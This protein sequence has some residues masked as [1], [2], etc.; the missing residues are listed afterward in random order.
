MLHA[1]M[2]VAVAAA[3]TIAL[4]FAPF[5]IFSGNRETPPLVLYLGK[6]LPAAIM[7]MLVVYCL[8]GTSFA[9]LSGWLPALLASLAVVGLHVWKRSSLLSI[10]GGTVLY[11]LLIRLL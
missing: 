10:L 1:G 9:A 5:L 7:G 6:V 3:V 2:I 4:R 8:R 11:M